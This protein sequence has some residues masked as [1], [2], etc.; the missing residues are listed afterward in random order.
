MRGL[1]LGL[2]AAQI[3]LGLAWLVLWVIDL[4]R[5]PAR[6]RLQPR[7]FRQWSVAL[8]LWFLVTGSWWIVRGLGG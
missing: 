4:G 6:R 7:R 2:G 1:E 3:A 5:D 8:G